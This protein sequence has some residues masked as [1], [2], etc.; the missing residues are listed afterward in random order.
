MGAIVS[1]GA[2]PLL[3]NCRVYTPGRIQARPGLASYATAAGANT[4]LHTVR[5]LNDFTVPDWTYICGIGFG[6]YFGKATLTIIGFPAFSGNPLSI[7]PFEPPSTPSP[8][9]YIMDSISGGKKVNV[10]GTLYNQGIAPPLNPPEVSLGPPSYQIIDLFNE[11]VPGLW[12]VSGTASALT[13]SPTGRINTTITEILYSSGTTGP[14][15]VIPE[16]NPADSFVTVGSGIGAENVIIQLSTGAPSPSTIQ[17][18]TYASGSTGLCM[19]LPVATSFTLAVGQLILINSGG[20]NQEYVIVLSFQYTGAGI[21][22]FTCVT[23]NTHIATESLTPIG[24]TLFFFENTHVNGDPI[25]AGYFGFTVG[26]GTGLLSQTAG[27]DLAQIQNRPQQTTDTI[28]LQVWIDVPT[29]VT[30]FDLLFDVDPMTNNFSVNYY[31]ATVV[32]SG[33][34]ASTWETVSVAISLFTPNGPLTGSSQTWANVAAIGIQATVTGTTN[35]RVSGL[36]IQGQYGPDSTASGAT[37]Y[38]YV[39]RY[40]S[41]VTGARS[42]ASPANRFGITVVNNSVAVVGSVAVDPQVDTADFFRLGGTLTNFLYIGSSPC[43]LTVI[44]EIIDDYADVDIASAEILETDNDQPFTVSGLPASGACSADGFLVT[45]LFGA[46]FNPQWPQGTEIIVGGIPTTLYS[47]PVKNG[48]VYTLQTVDS[49]GVMTNVMFQVPQPV[50]LDQPMQVMFG[51]YGEGNAGITMFACG[52]TLNAGTLFWTNGNNADSAGSANNL[53]ITS[54][55][56]PLMNGGV[57]ADQPFVFSIKRLFRLVPNFATDA[58]GN[59]IG[60]FLAYDEGSGYG[61]FG[62][63]ALAVG[64]KIYYLAGDASSIRENVLGGSSVSITDPDISLLFP[65]G[66]SAAV[67]VQI[68]GVVVQPPNFTLQSKLRLSWGNSHLY[69]DYIDVNGSNTSLVWN[70]VT[71]TWG[72]DTGSFGIVTHYADEAIGVDSLLAGGANGILY[73][74]TSAATLDSQFNFKMPQ[75]GDQGTY[76]LCRD[77]YLGAAISSGSGAEIVINVDGVDYTIPASSTTSNGYQRV[78]MNLPDLKGQVWS[79][80]FSASGPAEIYLKDTQAHIKQWA[81]KDF[82]FAQPFRNLEYEVKP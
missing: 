35:I 49:L 38:Q 62:P 45:R 23:V 73:E 5:R 18:I 46:F 50:L 2:Y 12:V 42:N 78:F 77:L 3:Q 47:Q 25:T 9:A 31:S 8:W 13:E 4:P 7:I 57:F 29:N 79:W 26:T 40:R 37:T 76:L 58:L 43:S 55:S 20:G 56:E 24:T 60:G 63:W 15:S 22:Q 6:L 71:R 75:V 69:F 59:P 14:A 32:V 74:F 82:K 19:I 61:L 27:F 1:L 44:P 51:R 33:F 54:P 41:S 52:N 70:P 64:P 72:L 21:P 34:T 17:T 53:Q 65:H 39:Y 16:V 10:S 81:D 67:P 30:S 80:G 11:A 28:Q 36:N 66:E 48:S 68:G